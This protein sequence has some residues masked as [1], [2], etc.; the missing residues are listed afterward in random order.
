MAFAVN[1]LEEFFQTL[2]LLLKLN[3][4]REVHDPRLNRGCDFHVGEQDAGLRILAIFILSS[5][6]LSKK[7]HFGHINSADPNMIFVLQR[8][9]PVITDKSRE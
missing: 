1:G 4:Q 6:P 9:T 3:S 8:T 7:C 2:K 5:N